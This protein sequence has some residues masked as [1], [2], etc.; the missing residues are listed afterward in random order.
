M[1]EQTYVLLCPNYFVTDCRF[2]AGFTSQIHKNQ[3]KLHN[4]WNYTT[5]AQQINYDRFVQH[6]FLLAQ[7]LQPGVQGNCN[8]RM[9]SN[10]LYY[11]TQNEDKYN[12]QRTISFKHTI[13]TLIFIICPPTSP[14]WTSFGPDNVSSCFDTISDCLPLSQKHLLILIT[15]HRLRVT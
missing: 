4:S 9:S 11:T 13:D 15:R 2:Y 7:P 5:L 10:Q 12:K 3:L 8:W 1:T 6:R 14:D